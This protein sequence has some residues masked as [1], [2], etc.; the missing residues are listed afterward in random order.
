MFIFNFNNLFNLF[1][2]LTYETRL[3]TSRYYSDYFDLN[4]DDDT[5][6]KC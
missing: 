4:S 5:F 2:C 1:E 3:T 6:Y